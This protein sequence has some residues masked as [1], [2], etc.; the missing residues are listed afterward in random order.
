MSWVNSTAAV[1][2][3]VS[4]VLG[5]AVGGLSAAMPQAILA[6]TPSEETAAAMSVNGVVRAVGFSIGSALS[7]LLLAAY[8][9]PGQ[10]VPADPGYTIAALTAAGLAVVSIALAAIIDSAQR[11]RTRA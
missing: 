1:A 7:G 11:R 5:F 8:T 9:S 3:S 4:G 10:F 2:S 6:V